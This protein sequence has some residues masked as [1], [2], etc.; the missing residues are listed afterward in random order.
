MINKRYRAEL[1]S[2]LGN[3]Y[4]IDIRPG[5]SQSPSTHTIDTTPEGFTL[6]YAGT[7]TDFREPIKGSEVNVLVIIDDADK[8]AFISDI[9]SEQS[10]TYVVE[11]LKKNEQDSLFYNYWTGYIWPEN[12]E[13]T[14]S[15][16]PYVAKIS[17]SDSAGRFK[18]YKGYP[19]NANRVWEL[20]QMVFSN[21]SPSGSIGQDG[22]IVLSSG[23]TGTLQKLR[24]A[25]TYTS[26][27]SSPGETNLWYNLLKSSSEAYPYN[28]NTTHERLA[29][30]K[31]WLKNWG[32]RVFLEDGYYK[33]IEFR[34]QATGSVT[35]AEHDS[36]GTPTGATVSENLVVQAGNK[37]TILDDGKFYYKQPYRRSELEYIT[38][39]LQGAPKSTDIR[40]YQISGV[41]SRSVKQIDDSFGDI[42]AYTLSHSTTGTGSGTDVT[43]GIGN[44][45][46]FYPASLVDIYQDNLEW[47][48]KLSQKYFSGTVRSKTF[49]FSNLLVIGKERYLT[50]SVT[51]VAAT[52]E[53]NGEWVKVDEDTDL[54]WMNQ[55]DDQDMESQS[56]SGNIKFQE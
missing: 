29:V 55:N 46:T 49:R 50:N 44:A 24:F 5:D 12:V 10:Q 6:E 11:I 45:T 21:Y 53:W 15:A 1:K 40:I 14:Y 19:Y 27:A 8:Q 4:K 18:D 17:A 35:W 48:F 52:D 20:F 34:Y 54:I 2:L 36:N 43:N 13:V 33:V 38:G 28:I 3:E 56:T 9:A 31:D 26:G 25:S 47:F 39:I 51:L 23:S 30:I 37:H 41:N 32:C 22:N 7:S 42:W 16:F